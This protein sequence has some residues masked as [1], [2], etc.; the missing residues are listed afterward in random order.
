MFI[1][2]NCTLMLKNNALHFPFNF[3]PVSFIER[4]W[5]ISTFS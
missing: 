3:D 5:L 2:R 4:Y 1:K